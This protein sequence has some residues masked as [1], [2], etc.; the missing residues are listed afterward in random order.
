MKAWVQVTGAIKG[1]HAR[2][3]GR[4]W[5]EAQAHDPL[6]AGAPIATLAQ[7]LTLHAG[8]GTGLAL[9]PQARKA[10]VVPDKPHESGGEAARAQRTTQTGLRRRDARQMSRRKG[11]GI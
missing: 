2:T 6:T 1:T 7:A 10:G 5:V 3:K 11:I 4:G 8:P 9:P